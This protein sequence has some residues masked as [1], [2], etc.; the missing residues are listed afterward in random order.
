MDKVVR[1]R[2]WIINKIED[3]DILSP[4]HLDKLYKHYSRIRMW[5]SNNEEETHRD[6]PHRK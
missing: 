4:D 6:C 3:G 2:D 1:L 5:E